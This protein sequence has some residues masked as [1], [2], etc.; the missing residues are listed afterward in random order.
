MPTESAHF[1]FLV[2][3]RDS[4][5]YQTYHHS[6]GRSRRSRILTHMSEQSGSRQCVAGRR[7]SVHACWL[8]PFASS[9]LSILAR[10]GRR[11]VRRRRQPITNPRLLSDRRR[12]LSV[13][14]RAKCLLPYLGG[15]SVPRAHLRR[16]RRV[17]VRGFFRHPGAPPALSQGLCE[18]RSGTVSTSRTTDELKC[19]SC[20]TAQE[21]YKAVKLSQV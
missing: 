15:F 16:Y 10:A 6:E 21:C 4:L 2:F 7:W 17:F 1:H 13:G 5:R 14:G 8:M 11:I 9:P 20:S 18:A 19:N 12:N 3:S